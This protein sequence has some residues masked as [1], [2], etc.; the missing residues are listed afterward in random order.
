MSQQCEYRYFQKFFS[1]ENESISNV[2][3]IIEDS[4]G[5]VWI[6]TQ[7]GLFKFDGKN[8]TEF[9]K[10]ATASKKMIS[11]SD[12]RDI[13]IFGTNLWCLNSFGGLDCIDINTSEVI[14]SWQQSNKPEFKNTLL[15]S[16]LYNKDKLIIAGDNGLYNFE[17]RTRKLKKLTIYSADGEDLSLYYINKICIADNN[18]WVFIKNKGVFVYDID[19]Y[20]PICEAQNPTLIYYDCLQSGSNNI[21]AGTN[22]GLKNFFIDNNKLL[23]ST[24][25]FKHARQEC[26]AV[27]KD[28]SQAIWFTTA[29]GLFKSTKELS[30]VTQVLDSKVENNKDWT[31][32]LFEL[33]FDTEDYLWIGGQEGFAVCANK[34]PP[35]VAYKK[36]ASSNTLINRAYFIYPISTTEIYVCAT[37]GLYKVNPENR[38]IVALA[39]GLPFLYAFTDLENKLIFS[40]ADGL[41]TLSDHRLLPI[42]ISYPEFKNLKPIIS[43]HAQIN[44]STL[45]LG[46]QNE[47][48]YYTWQPG[49]HLLKHINEDNPVVDLNKGVV[50]QVFID[51]KG[52]IWLLGD[53]Y[54]IL[55]NAT[56]TAISNK[57]I[58][59]NF[60]N[61][62]SIFFD[63]CQVGGKYYI[64]SYGNG[65]VCLNSDLEVTKILSTKNGLANNGVYKLFSYKDSLLFAS[66]NK[67]LSVININ[68]NTIKNYYNYDGIHG[69]N[70]EELSGNQKAGKIYLGGL[71]GFTIISPGLIN[72]NPL[73]PKVYFKNIRIKID[74]DLIDTGNVYLDR[75]NIANNAIQADVFF[76]AINWS[77]PYQTTFSYRILEKSREWIDL[78]TQNFVT[79]IGLSPGTYHLQVKAA[80]ED[81]I[82]SEPKELILVFLPKWYQTWW[83]KL[84]VLAGIAGIVYAFY[85][86]RIRQIKKQHAI[87][88]N[89]ANDLHD[90]LGSTLNSVK[91]FTN[92]A[93]SGVKQEESLQQV[94]QNLNEATMGLRDMI[95]VLDDSLDTVDELITRL[96]Q[97]AVPVTGASNIEVVIKADSGVND[98]KL[99]KEEKRNLF[100]ICKEI[101][102][103][104]IKYSEASTITINIITNRKNIQITITDN[105]KGFD[106]QTVKKGYGLKNMQY[107][108]EQIRYQVKLSS[109]S[110]NGTSITILPL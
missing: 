31:N 58:A 57:K 12:V 109:S 86:Y 30:T 54:I 110:G 39:T 59:D 101:I 104:S 77:N 24:P 45:L 3:K 4:L 38:E 95:W 100:L 75:F 22:L 85:R 49:K 70:F 71:D 78:N 91:V 87:R 98:R 17:V 72:S 82:W 48:G 42:S 43:S 81:G 44:D 32:S 97:Y 106:P 7:D 9:N 103:N 83:F 99:N 92:L 55:C 62:Y 108:A 60:G 5:F 68:T 53:N 33:Y 88:K 20:K 18:L 10:A 36:S 76:S 69:N 73:P 23:S 102:N 40:N 21:I 35:F 2:R 64:A 37:D 74:N 79:L 56:G 47:Q 8:I 94:K 26:F 11:G 61:V 96:K 19:S 63:I 27:E 34:I 16:F 80:N 46:T 13:V 51:K 15:H 41:V 67:G 107:R 65:V 50:N 93:I 52:I 84:L 66:T 105:G 90:D 6:A 1:K 25:A 89:I 28:K 29:S 14:Y